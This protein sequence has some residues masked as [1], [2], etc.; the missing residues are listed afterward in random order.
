M[1]VPLIELPEDEDG[2]TLSL[3]VGIIRYSDR[4]EDFPL[5]C[6]LMGWLEFLPLHM[7][8]NMLTKTVTAWGI[9]PKFDLVEQGLQ[10]PQYMITMTKKDKFGGIKFEVTKVEKVTY[11][12]V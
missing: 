12:G 10:A 6:K 5:L 4:D 3:R 9:S 11:S 2:I 1:K 8:T 7:T